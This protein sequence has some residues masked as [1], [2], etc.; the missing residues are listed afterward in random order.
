MRYREALSTSANA[1]TNIENGQTIVE[2]ALVVAII[3][4]GVTVALGVALVGGVNNLAAT[5]LSLLS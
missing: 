1:V 4:V 3:S 5:I 2:Y